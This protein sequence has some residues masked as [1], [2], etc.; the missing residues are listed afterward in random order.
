[1][2]T[3]YSSIKLNDKQIASTGNQYYIY[4]VTNYTNNVL[5][6]GVTN[7]LIKRI[8]QHKEKYTESFTKKY[9]CN[10]L[11]YFE[12]YQDIN[13][14]LETIFLTAVK[15]PINRAL[16]INPAMVIVEVVQEVVP[17]DI[18]RLT[19]AAQSTCNKFQVFVKRF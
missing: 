7:N 19:F 5:Y 12:I 18:L 3:D 6:T 9:N 13:Q 16:L 17:N 15:L 2:N 11:V 4:M 10:K 8:H 1:M 14:A